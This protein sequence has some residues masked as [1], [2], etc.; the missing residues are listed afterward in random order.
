[1]LKILIAD[2]HEIVRTGLKQILREEYPFAE[3]EEAEDGNM[4]V[5][6]AVRAHWDIVISDLAMPALS[7]LD[8]LKVI[9]E[10]CPGCPVLILSMYPEDQY[11][12]RVI[13]AGAAGY[14]SKDMAQEE[15]I[16]AV[17]R[18]LSGKKYL[19]PSLADQL[20][21][22][23]AGSATPHDIL[24]DRELIVMK[25]IGAGKSTSDISQELNLSPTTI[26]T[27]RSRILEKMKMKSNAEITRYVIENNLL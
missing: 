4:L 27:Y 1:M 14:L 12:I 19:N 18:V 17:R 6:K 3:I 13:K 15:L 26:S 8:A 9:K 23:T 20:I 16:N 5:E 7:G 11:A 10:K 25:M 21:S 22:I 24:S 2:D